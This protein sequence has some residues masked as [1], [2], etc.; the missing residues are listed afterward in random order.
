MV[1]AGLLLGFFICIAEPDLHILAG[2]VDYISAGKI[3]KNLL[4]VVVSAGV[5]LLIAFGFLRV[6]YNYPLH[7]SLAITYG[8]ILLL[9]LF[10]TPEF[11]A[12]A[13]DASGATTGALTVPFI[14][15]L[16]AG[17]SV[18]KKDIKSS[19]ED[20]FGL[21][22]LASAGAIM[23]V[24]ATGVLTNTG[25]LSG[26]LPAAE[27]VAGTVL[28]P[29]LQQLPVIA[30][31]V[32][33]ALLPILVVFFLFQKIS[34]KLSGRALRRIIFGLVFAF[35]GLLLFLTGVNA[36]FLDVGGVFAGK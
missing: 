28:S 27:A 24:L 7:K 5:G 17:I 14:L 21:V 30:G 22:G 10:S 26:S 33:L 29:F 2:Q 25:R 8:I 6:L 11:L 34:F 9:A 4:L 20:S 32:S 15:A 36:G 1:V 23:A 31:E 12:V 16:A 18:L 3:G 35:L 13:F 19:E